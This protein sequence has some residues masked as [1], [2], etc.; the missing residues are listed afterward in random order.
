MPWGWRSRHQF[1]MGKSNRG[2]LPL[3][4]ALPLTLCD[5]EPVSSP[6]WAS[7]STAVKPEV[8]TQ[9][10]LQPFPARACAVLFLDPKS[11]LA[12]AGFLLPLFK[13]SE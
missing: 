2:H 3:H 9:G 10:S 1:S 6:L 4:P 13:S 5:L 11:F 7:V 8:R 12:A